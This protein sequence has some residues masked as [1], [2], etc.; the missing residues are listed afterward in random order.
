M[1]GASADRLA[2]SL[3]LFFMPVEVFMC[4]CMHSGEPRL[5]TVHNPVAFVVGAQKAGTTALF[6][7][8]S[9][10][11]STI[12]PYNDSSLYDVLRAK[13]PHILDQVDLTDKDLRRYRRSNRTRLLVDFTPDY[14]DIPTATCR[15]ATHFS[16]AKVVYI[17][18]DPAARAI[19]AWI[20]MTRN[21]RLHK[22]LQ[23]G[24]GNWNSLFEMVNEEAQHLA[25]MNCTLGLDW[26]Y[27]LGWN[28]EQLARDWQTCFACHFPFH[29]CIARRVSASQNQHSKEVCSIKHFGLLRQGLYAP[30]LAWLLYLLD[31]SNILVLSFA[32]IVLHTK[33]ALARIFN[34]LGLDASNIDI[35][36]LSV[37]HQHQYINANERKSLCQQPDFAR[38][39]K[40]LYHVFERPKVMLKQVLHSHGMLTASLEK[41][42]DHIE[43]NCSSSAAPPS[44][45]LMQ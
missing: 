31:H 30:Q 2:V 3:I 22:L 39:A 35:N 32:D 24:D 29:P 6:Q 1:G 38:V 28:V 41:G 43:Y 33:N 37:K 45:Q 44:H 19:S 16:R 9:K 20:M 42:L 4:A 25:D 8:I 40:H 10:H 36:A 11:V 23:I 5:K 7:L 13:E 12:Y 26:Q 17:V 18:R 15:I 14:S 21:T 34:F 27:P